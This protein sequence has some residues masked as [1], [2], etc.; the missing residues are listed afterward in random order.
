MISVRIGHIEFRMNKLENRAEA[1][2]KELKSKGIST[3][4]EN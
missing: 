3:V 4:L 2:A 1:F